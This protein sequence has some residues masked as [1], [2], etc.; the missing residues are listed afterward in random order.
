MSDD[1]ILNFIMSGTRQ[2]PEKLLD[3]AKAP[4]YIQKNI[5]WLIG[6]IILGIV[7]IWWFIIWQL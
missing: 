6:L 2:A 4:S 3:F 7:Y 5:I 1:R